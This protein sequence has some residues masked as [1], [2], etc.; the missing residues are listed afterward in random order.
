MSDI[1]GRF[2]DITKEAETLIARGGTCFQRFT[3]LVCGARQTMP[4]PDVFYTRGRCDECGFVT[5]L[6]EHGCGFMLIAS[7]NPQAHMEFVQDV[8][9]SIRTAQPRNR[10]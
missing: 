1:D 7:S 3:C 6:R 10:N 8:A 2:E 9:E 4:D 5:D